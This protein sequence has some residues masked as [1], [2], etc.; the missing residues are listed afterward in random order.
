MGIAIQHDVIVS[1]FHMAAGI[2]NVILLLYNSHTITGM[3][4]TMQQLQN[5]KIADNKDIRIMDSVSPDWE[6]VAICMGFEAHIINTIKRDNLDSK[7]A[8]RQLFMKWLEGKHCEQHSWEKLSH[9]L[10]DAGFSVIA[11]DL[12]KC[13]EY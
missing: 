2:I 3:K 10:E 8:T 6:D 5:I 1:S 13:F 4:P 12:Q 11:L 7:G 9:C